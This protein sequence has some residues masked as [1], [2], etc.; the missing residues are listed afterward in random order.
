MWI[1]NIWFSWYRS[2]EIGAPAQQVWSLEFKSQ[3]HQNIWFVISI[4]WKYECVFKEEVQLLLENKSTFKNLKH[5]VFYKW[6]FK[7]G[8]VICFT[9]FTFYRILI[10]FT[11]FYSSFFMTLFW[12]PLLY[13]ETIWKVLFWISHKA[14]YVCKILAIF[15]LFL[16]NS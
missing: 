4:W 14:P 3:C 15:R 13:Y 12:K 10:W 5:I 9:F 16:I 8:K 6:I 2:Q 7:V 1:Q 11:L